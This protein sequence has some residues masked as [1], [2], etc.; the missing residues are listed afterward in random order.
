M[1]GMYSG[2]QSQIKTINPLAEYV[3]CATH[4]LKLVG[5]C[6]TEYLSEAVDCFSTLQKFYIFSLLKKFSQMSYGRMKEHLFMDK[7]I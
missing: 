1:L 5:A 4:S 7:K 3:P 6:A 2:L